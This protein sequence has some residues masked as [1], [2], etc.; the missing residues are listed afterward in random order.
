[1]NA[2]LAISVVALAGLG[3]AISC[4]SAETPAADTPRGQ[5]DTPASEVEEPTQPQ[6]LPEDTPTPPP[7]SATANPNTVNPGTYIVGTDIQPGI[8]RGEAGEGFL[9]SCYWARL[10]NLSGELEGI[11]ANDNSM[12]QFYIEVDTTDF[13][14]ETGCELEFLPTL[15]EPPAQFPETIRP[16]TYLVG[17]DIQ[18]GTYR[19]QAGQDFSESCYWARLADLSGELSG[20]LANDN[21]MGQFYVQVSSSDVALNTG[22]ELTRVA[23]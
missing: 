1:M 3:A 19:G 18:P 21:A 8:F 6:A 10:A 17:I 7:P 15:P 16:G 20:I 2:R 9:D 22:C 14:L 11:L 23:D 5:P 4:G 12:G 13:A